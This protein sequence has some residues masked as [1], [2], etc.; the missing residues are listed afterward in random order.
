MGVGL[1]N[2][3][4]S[5]IIRYFFHLHKQL[6]H[7]SKYYYYKDVFLILEAMPDTPED[8]KIKQDFIQELKKQNVVYIPK[9][10]FDEKLKNLSYYSLFQPKEN[11]ETL[12]KDL[13]QFC[14]ELKFKVEDDIIFENIS[15]FEN[16]FLTLFHLIQSYDFDIKIEALEVLVNQMLNLENI[17]FVGEPLQGLQVMGLL[18]TRL[19]NFKNVIMLSVNEGKLP[20][21]NTQNTYIPFD[22]RKRHNMHTFLENDGIYAYHFYRL[23][24]DSEKVFLIY[25]GVSSGMNTGEMSRFITQLE[26]ESPHQIEK[27]VVENLSQPTDN[28]LITIEKTPRVKELLHD[29]KKNIAPTHL[30]D[31]LVNPL[32]FYMKNLLKVRETRD[33]EEEL[34]NVEYGNLVHKALEVLYLPFKGEIL[35]LQ[36]FD[37]MF[38]KIDTAID[39]AITEKKHQKEFYQKGINYI[40]KVQAQKTIEKIIQ[41]DR[42]L[43]EKGNVLKIIELEYRIENVVFKLNDTENVIFN[44]FIDRIDCLNNEIRII[45][46]KSK[47]ATTKKLEIKA[48]NGELPSF[49][50]DYSMAVQLLIYLYYM[51]EFSA[52]K[53]YEMSAGIWDLS[54]PSF[55]LHILKFLECDYLSAM[56]GV[57][58]I[59][60]E[61]LDENIPFKEAELIKF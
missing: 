5:N 48:K 15:Y 36:D 31:Y 20:L 54:K 49:T 61:I 56:Q 50:K 24:Q 6:G 3:N 1:K 34:S 30:N 21:G 12:L 55:G 45:D 32:N 26:I 23:L 58:E 37:S 11:T 8:K 27:Y 47:I 29:W 4:F 39:F 17:D 51:E 38:S 33:I 18:E 25:N 16:T 41:V 35:K 13:A 42:D 43:V 53:G 40:L 10:L 28:Q 52:Y 9:K 60:L 22:V 2:L 57:R 46:Y 7:S 14:F 19:L 44:G 59:I